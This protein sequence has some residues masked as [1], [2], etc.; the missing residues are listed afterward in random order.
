VLAAPFE[1]AGR[2]NNIIL[3]FPGFAVGWISATLARYIY[4][5]PK[6]YRRDPGTTP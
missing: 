2:R 4:P 1:P 5:P 3:V 6:K